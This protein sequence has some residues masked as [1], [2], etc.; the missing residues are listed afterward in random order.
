MRPF[1]KAQLI[2]RALQ[3]MDEGGDEYVEGQEDRTTNYS[4]SRKSDDE[5]NEVRPLAL[6]SKYCG[7]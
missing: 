4:S 2:F 7:P 1:P 5:K 3:N 6:R